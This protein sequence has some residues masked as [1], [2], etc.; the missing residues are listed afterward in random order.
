MYVNER[1]IKRENVQMKPP[2]I[3][4]HNLIWYVLCTFC[5]RENCI[6]TLFI[7]GLFM[8]LP[9]T[10]DEKTLPRNSARCNACNL[11]CNALAFLGLHR[12]RI[13]DKPN[14]FH[15]FIVYRILIWNFVVF[16]YLQWF[17]QK[18]VARCTYSGLVPMWKHVC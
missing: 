4:H 12:I 7:W 10:T 2:K 16:F 17:L 8:C 3:C 6:I 15:M 14:F 11:M 9:G 5:S 13:N 1:E 18:F